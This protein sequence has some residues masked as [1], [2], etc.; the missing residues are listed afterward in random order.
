MKL[1][2]FTENDATYVGVVTED[3]VVKTD[4]MADVFLAGGRAAYAQL[5]ETLGDITTHAVVSLASLNIAPV[6]PSPGKIICIGLNYR[7]HAIESGMDIPQLP[8]LFSKYPNSISA[9]GQDV[10]MSLDWQQVDYESE[11]GVVIGKTAKHVSVDNALDYVLGYCNCN[12]LSERALQ[13]VSGQWMIGKTLDGFL[14]VGPYLVTTDDI[15][16]PQQLRIR[17]WMN[18]ELRQDS[19]TSDMVF[20]VAES[21]AYISK[22]MTLNPG[23][24]IST[25][26][27]EGVIF[28][29]PPEKQAWMKP[30]D[31][32]TVEIDSLGRLSN[33]L[34][35]ETR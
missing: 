25:G 6:V 29:Y 21:I 11:L 4:V 22:Y 27:P 13:F 23:D 34:V 18:G 5:K 16:D 33:R 9:H 10:P 30:G 1:V 24:L 3:G 20:S 8:V 19:H 12:D 28:G 15:P 35:E 26:T 31:E 2:M 17:G 32:Y 7:Q 14:P